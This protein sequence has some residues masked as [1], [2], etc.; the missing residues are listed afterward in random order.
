[1]QELADV[2]HEI[3]KYI[4]NHETFML[5]LTSKIPV[6][7]KYIAANKIY[8]FWYIKKSQ[9]WVNRIIRSSLM[10]HPF[11]NRTKINIECPYFPCSLRGMG[12][13]KRTKRFVSLDNYLV[14]SGCNYWDANAALWYSIGH[15]MLLSEPCLDFLC[16][17][18]AKL[19]AYELFDYYDA[20]IISIYNEYE[21]NDVI[22]WED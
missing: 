2:F 5:F 7:A 21:W 18:C 12:C 4:S 19:K 11:Y 10:R 1:M 16:Y 6:L 13:V 22:F 8:K 15:K 3:V 9:H 14:C 20:P 17:D